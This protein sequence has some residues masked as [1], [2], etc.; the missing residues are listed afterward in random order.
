[1]GLAVAASGD[2]ALSSSEDGTLRVWDLRSRRGVRAIVPPQPAGSAAPCG[3]FGS[4]AFGNPADP[5]TSV[6]VASGPELFAFDLRGSA[7]VSRAPPTLSAQLA[8]DI[9][10]FAVSP[11]GGLVAVPCDD[12]SVELLSLSDLQR[13]RTLRGGHQNICSAARYRASGGELVTGGFDQRLLLWD[14]AN[15]KLRAKHDARELFPAE[16]SDEQPNPNQLVNPPFV[17][18]LA[19]DGISDSVA[20]ALG[21]G[22]VLV[23]LGGQRQQR[24]ETPWVVPQAH[25]AATDGVTWL[26]SGSSLL[27]SA[28][29]DRA[30]RLWAVE[31]ASPSSRGAA[32]RRRKGGRD[33]AAV[34]GYRDQGFCGDADVVDA[35]CPKPVAQVQ[36]VDKPNALAAGPTLVLVADTSSDVMLLQ[37]RQ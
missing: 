15:G 16:E 22:A 7:I 28:G 21:D 1:M 33:V 24:R 13:Q 5:F 35:S 2:T 27:A 4:C 18:G 17:L 14:P 29:R 19:A 32:G 23:L 26:G 6:L 31:G 36:L 37:V 9:N 20:V 8:D 3:T 30:L 10:D 11:D 34:G 25:A 12:G